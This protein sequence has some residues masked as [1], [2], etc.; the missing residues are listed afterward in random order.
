VKAAWLLVGTVLVFVIHSPWFVL[1]IV[2]L[3]VVGLVSTGVP[4]VSIRGFRLFLSTALLLGLLQLVFAPSG[5][6]WLRLGPVQFTS[7]GLSAGV[8]IAGRFISVIL[9]SYSF[10]LTTEPNDLAYGLMQ[11]GLPYRYG[12]ALVTA[13]RLAPSFENEGRV[14]YKAQLARGLRYDVRSPRRLV[15]LARQFLLPLLTSALGRVDRLAVSM[16]GRCFGRY[17][18]RTYLRAVRLSWIDAIASF[19]LLVIIAVTTLAL[20]S[21]ALA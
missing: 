15:T 8:Y 16:E 4:V 20:H 12:F 3:L 17:R 10:V 21:G 14:V 2:L 18:K 13:L 7:G 9:L 5:L 11:A 6:E 19:L 1:S